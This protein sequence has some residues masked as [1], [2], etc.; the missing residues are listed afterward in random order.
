MLSTLTAAA[1]GDGNAVLTRTG[2][3]EDLRFPAGS[4]ELVVSNYAM[5]YLTDPDKVAV[6]ERVRGWLVPGGRLV[7]GDMMVGRSLD[8]HHRKALAEKAA[9]LLR[10]GPAGWWRLVKNLIRIGAG[11]GRL[12]PAAPEWWTG[13]LTEAGFLEVGYEHVVSEAGITFGIAPRG[14]DR[15]PTPGA[16]AGHS[17]RLTDARAGFARCTSRGVG[18]RF[19]ELLRVFRFFG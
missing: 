11:K 5:H 17:P 13:A 7:V 14:G 12:R 15:P 9:A 6:L 18:R 4:F 10:R 1:R 2:P 8:E 19:G 16:G 3:M